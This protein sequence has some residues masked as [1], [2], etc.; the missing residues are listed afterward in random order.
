MFINDCSIWV[1]S[2]TFVEEITICPTNFI[3]GI[4]G[5]VMCGIV[6]NTEIGPDV[7]SLLVEW[8][9]NNN[10]IVNNTLGY[11]VSLLAEGFAKEF[12]ST[13]KI[14]QVESSHSGNYTCVASIG[15]EN[16]KKI[17]KISVLIV[18]T[19]LNL[20]VFVSLFLF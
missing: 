1:F 10:N 4:P 19:T 3:I 11:N 15:E 2:D 6:L 16:Q 17:K 12:D 14:S 5:I 7:S 8:Y 18:C 13:L 9:H 20:L